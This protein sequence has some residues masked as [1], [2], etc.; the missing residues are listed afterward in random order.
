MKKNILPLILLASVIGSQPVF[1]QSST[2]KL[3]LLK[4]QQLAVQTSINSITTLDVMGQS[5][6]I[7][8]DAKGVFTVQ[9]KD[10]KTTGYLVG[11]TLTRMQ[12]KGNVMGQVFDFD[13]DNNKDRDSSEMGNLVKSQLGTEK[14][15][16]I[17]ENGVITNNAAKTNNDADNMMS[18]AGNIAG[19]GDMSN[20]S[21][22][23]FMV[24]PKNAQTGTT[25]TDSIITPGIK[26]Y[27]NFTITGMQQNIATVALTGTQ[28]TNTTVSQM[29]MEVAVSML[30]KLNGQIKVD[31][32]SGI[33][34]EKTYTADGSGTADAS[35]M[36]IP[37]T[38]KITSSTNVQK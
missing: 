35:G 13:S 6:E 27:R 38:T 24:L 11:S 26:T 21:A 30:L 3:N 37:I 7:I 36:S 9:V 25:W 23:A 10:K 34:V 4:G 12:V 32:V 15:I 5:Q 28:N 31:A 16:E 8:S 2:G 17:N 14:E 1:A 22:D 19:S 33:V 18:M 20:A 29:G